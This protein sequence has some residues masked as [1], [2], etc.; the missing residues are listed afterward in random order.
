MFELTES[1]PRS[2]KP[3]VRLIILLFGLIVLCSVSY[4]INGSIFPPDNASA[5]I[6]QGGLLL[7]I[8]GSLFL[9]DKFTRPAD[10]VV[11]ALTGIISLITVSSTQ[12]GTHWNLIFIY[13]GIVFSAGVGCIALGVPG[14]S[15]GTQAKFSHA[16]Y[17]LSTVLG[18]SNVLFSI[19][20]LYAV[21][22]F[23]GL[24]SRQTAA[25]VAFW[26]L[27]VVIWPLKLP[28]ILQAFFDRS[29]IP[30]RCGSILRMETPNVMRVELLP[31]TKWDNS[32]SIVACTGD[33]Q[34]RV[35]LPL[36]ARIQDK[37]LIGTGLCLESY[38]SPVHNAKRGQV[39]LLDSKPKDAGE[40][41]CAHFCLDSVAL[42][43]GLVSEGSRIGKI[44]FETWCPQK[45]KEGLLV[46]CQIS[47]E[48]VFYQ[49]TE[50]NTREEIL[51]KN[52]HGLQIAEA[53]QLGTIKDGK[54]FIKYP[55]LPEIHTAVFVAGEQ[56]DVSSPELESDE[57]V[58]GQ[59][60]G[61]SV[62]VVASIKDM[63]TYH[64]AIL[65]V[66]GTGKT[67][68][69]YDFIR[70][71]VSRDVK[72]FCVDL[73]GLYGDR[74]ADL[75]P[76]ELSIEERKAAELEEKFFAIETGKPWEQKAPLRQFAS[77]LRQDIEKRVKD[78]LDSDDHCIGL[79]NLPTISNTKATITV[80]EMYLSSI[81]EYAR[82]YPEGSPILVVLEEAHTVIPESSTMG[83]SDFGSKAM[84]AKIA[85]IA[86]QG[87]KYKVGLLVLAQRT[88]TVS[89]TVL[90]Q[91]NTVIS[92]SCFD[93]TSIT[94]L[95]NFFGK[96][97]ANLVPN[98]GFLQAVMFG[99]GIKS[100]R[101]LIVEIPYDE[102]KNQVGESRLDNSDPQDP[103][104]EVPP[105]MEE[106]PPF[107]E[108][109]LVVMEEELPFIEEP[110]FLEEEPAFMKEAPCFSEEPPPFTEVLPFLARIRRDPT[111]SATYSWSV[112]GAEMP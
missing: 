11:N 97:H 37:T 94:F 21:L 95:T 29:H 22:A 66:T 28:H 65:G 53:A 55:W 5:N 25:L 13:C 43:I 77:T 86:L 26:G 92:F 19:I 33:G 27:Y 79:F 85:Q 16:L 71:A 6:F 111:Q 32:I 109:E 89:K 102:Q 88:A 1:L 10:A 51:A 62:S 112:D 4:Y 54:K 106:A 93:Q 36:F 52:I 101:P 35:V 59:V 82:R 60:P 50:G 64:T 105:F 78:F 9:E 15:Q 56:P 74:L 63:L 99:K 72:V 73:T 81:L 12:A 40:A 18:K 2:V 47:G 87:R 69:A 76:Q 107:S 108:E 30:N 84:V 24:Q 100:E 110:H 8:L 20:F 14:E 3:W 46:F 75:R 58:I 104:E 57:F 83:L 98:L 48:R 41:I 38:Q 39:Y 67:E 31:N 68:L 103:A 90:T 49:I 42:P 80:T 45:C 91:C 23:Y 61:S 34:Q 17:V 7:V 96:D 70:E 44:N